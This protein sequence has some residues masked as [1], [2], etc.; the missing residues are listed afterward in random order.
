M[1][2]VLFDFKEE[3][4]QARINANHYALLIFIMGIV[5]FVANTIQ[6]TIFTYIGE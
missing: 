1:V 6:H 4:E 5:S 3:P 2:G